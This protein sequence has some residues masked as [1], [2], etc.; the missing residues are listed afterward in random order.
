VIELFRD[1]YV[2]Q[3]LPA[4]Y[5]KSLDSIIV[6]DIHIGFEEEMARKGIYLPRL[7][8]RKFIETVTRAI[9]SFKTNKLIIN[10]DI[11][12]RLDGLGF[13]ER[14]DL[15]EVF[16]ILKDHGVEIRLIRGNHDTYI[17]V[18]I[19]KFDNI[20]LLDKIEYDNIIIFHGHKN[21][22]PEKG[23][24][25]II[26]HEHPRLS[27]RDRIGI[28]RKFACFLLSPLKNEANV[29]VLPAL[30]GYQAGNDVSL[31]HSSY[32][33]NLMREYSI[34]EKAKPYI[35]IEGEGI[36]EFP[37]LRFLKDLIL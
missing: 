6:S 31:S 2:D 19:E 33:T 5:F 21:I 23:K 16:K 35:I 4:I 29:V 20:V 3:D 25:Y 18:V 14:K 36:M 24:T 26:G 34:L 32:M 7:Q 12:H 28:A 30:G 13:Q 11:K 1:F 27:I 10:G 22:I 9:E 15:E 8:K 17:S 37:E